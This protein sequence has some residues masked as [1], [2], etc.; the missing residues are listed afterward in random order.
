MY[1]N[2]SIHNLNHFLSIHASIVN[3][4]RR[5]SF[6][7][8]VIGFSVNNKDEINREYGKPGAMQIM[9]QLD[10]VLTEHAR[11]Y[12]PFGIITDRMLFFNFFQVMDEYELDLI[13]KRFL[14]ILTSTEFVI[15]D[16]R[17]DIEIE[18]RS[19]IIPANEL[20]VAVYENEEKEYLGNQVEILLD[21]FNRLK[22]KSEENSTD[23][24]E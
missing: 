4:C 14:R 7:L 5:S 19:I 17:V 18:N 13:N 12:E 21:K 24:T 20:P 11:N 16:K 2:T 15:A 8:A 6:S 9:R 3:R 10:F 23:R 1:R 22:S